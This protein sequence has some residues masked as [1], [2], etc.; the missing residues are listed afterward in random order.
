VQSEQAKVDEEQVEAVI[1]RL[2]DSHAQWVPVE[3]GVGLRFHDNSGAAA[4]D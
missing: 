4:P 1:Q 3:R 2:R